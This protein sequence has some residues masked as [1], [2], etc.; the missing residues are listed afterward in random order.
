M[1]VIQRAADRLLTA[2][3]PKTTAAACWVCRYQECYCAGGVLYL[4]Y[5]CPNSVCQAECGGCVRH[6]IAC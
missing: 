1:T 3:V 4:Q 5:C 2:L 6:A